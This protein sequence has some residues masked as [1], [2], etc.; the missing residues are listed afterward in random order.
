MSPRLSS[1]SPEMGTATELIFVEGGSTDDT[2]AEIERQ[3]SAHPERDISVL[4]QQGKGK[5][6]AVRTGF[7]AAKH[8]LMILDGDV[9]VLPEG[10]AQK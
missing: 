3:I 5:G 4:A 9:S 2:R 1:A 8:D 10:S 7:A 6:A